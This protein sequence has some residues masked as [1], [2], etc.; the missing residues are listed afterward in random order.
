MIKSIF[1][2]LGSALSI[3]ESKEAKKYLTKVL[4]LEKRYDAEN[5]KENIDHNI[6]DR[7]ERDLMRLS[8]LVSLEIKRS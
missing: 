6:L 2:L 4:D 5:D 8:D 1:K 7:I 3:W